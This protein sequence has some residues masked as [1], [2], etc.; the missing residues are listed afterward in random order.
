M[1][2][3]LIIGATS[4]IA[5]ACARLWA[6][7]GARFFLAARHAEKLASLASDLEVRG[8][9]AVATFQMDAND[10][11][12]HEAML[13][14]A[15]ADGLD[16]ALIAHGSLPDQAACER[17]AALTLR[18]FTTNALSVIALLTGL[19]SRFERQGAGAL[20]VI[21][22]VAGDRGRPGNYV[23]GSAKAAVSTF[24]EGLRARLFRSGVSLTDIRPGFVDTPM[25]RGLSLPRLLTSTPEAVARR[26]VAGVEKKADVCYA[27]FFWR[28][29]MALI[30]HFPRVLFKRMRF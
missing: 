10:T 19:A 4:A 24:C 12:I 17:D 25:T 1:K 13:E 23:Y 30:R 3:I 7:E 14:Q 26:I 2:R 9:S 11:A 20:A 16:I 28:P 29:I 6:G 22:S 18:E 21:T 15:F 8:A 27:P 5:T